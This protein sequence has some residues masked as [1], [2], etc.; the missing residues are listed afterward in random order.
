M[1]GSP[2][3]ETK[4]L[5]PLVGAIDLGS[6]SIRFTVFVAATG[7]LVTYHQL[8][9]ETQTPKPGWLE[10]NP[11]DIISA[12]IKCIDAT[13]LNLEKLDIE[14]VDVVAVGVASQRCTAIAWDKT[15]GCLMYPGCIMAADVRTQS[16]VDELKKSRYI[17]EEAI[18]TLSG[19]PLSTY[20]SAIKFKWL[21]ENDDQVK[22]ALSEDRLLLGTCNSY[23]MW[24]LTGGTE[25]GIH[26]TD[27]TNASLTGLMNLETLAWDEKLCKYF[28]VPIDILPK[29][30][31]CS[32]VYGSLN[33]SC[34][35]GIPVSGCIGDQ[36]AALIGQ[37]CWR[38]GQ[39]KISFGN[40]AFTL[41]NVGPKLLHSQFGLLSTVAYKIGENPPIYA[42]EGSVKEAGSIISWL[43]SIGISCHLDDK[44][45]SSK[46]PNYDNNMIL[47]PSSSGC[48]SPHWRSSCEG[49]IVGLTTCSPG[50]SNAEDI[51]QAALQAVA[52]QNR[53]VLEAMERDSKIKLTTILT[54]GGN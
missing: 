35:K 52:F 19:L 2:G 3:G 30:R 25:G 48:L 20:F 5:G 14:P 36:Q 24:A 28:G 12:V 53:D 4:K 40:G 33:I 38:P 47:I 10:L 11:N 39:A 18:R 6:C 41:F 49:I 51:Y 37:N 27:V 7:E 32:E 45:T 34:L 9:V 29:I 50:T 26:I 22:T 13:V 8:P 1:I 31:S 23:L 54:D 21:L 15:T 42:F 46:Q 43:S 44:T 16:L 17:K